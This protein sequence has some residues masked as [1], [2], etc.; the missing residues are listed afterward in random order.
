M[1]DLVSG[2]SAVV[3]AVGR[4]CGT[5]P[6][7]ERQHSSDGPV[8]VVGTDLAAFDRDVEML[9]ALARRAGHLDV[10]TGEHRRRRAV[11]AEPVADDQ[12]VESPLA[13]EQLGQQP[14]VLT[15]ERPVQAVV[16]GHDH[17]NAGLADGG[18][19]RH[20]VQLAERALV[21]L[22]RDRH[23]FELGVVADEVFD[24]RRH[25]LTLQPAHVGDSELGGQE[26]V[27]AEALE[28]ASADRRA[29][30]VHGRGEHDVGALRVRLPPERPADLLD[31]RRIPR[32]AEGRAAWKRGRRRTGPGRATDPGRAVRHA[33]RRDRRLVERGGV[34]RVGPRQ[35]GD[36]LVDAEPGE[37]FLVEACFHGRMVATGAATW[38]F[39]RV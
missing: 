5:G 2:S 27:L 25:A 24:A 13:A 10:E 19:E 17:A 32:R 9:A 30:E 36:L 39:E 26:W 6:L 16:P 37:E 3:S 23:P 11:R 18:L 28:V 15:A 22:R 20:Q 31:Q 8:E 4:V 35:Q 29:V 34:P 1:T 12:T 14:V 21:D 7:G 38:G 33:D